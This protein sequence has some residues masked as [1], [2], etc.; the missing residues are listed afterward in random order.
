M[1][2]DSV[3]TASKKAIR[4]RA[5]A[6]AA[7]FASSTSE[8]AD[9]QTFWNEFFA[10]F[11]IDRKQVAAFE[12]LAKRA[13][14]GNHGWIDLLY[15]GKMGVEHKSAGENLDAAMG[16]LLDY[17]PSLPQVEH[18]WLLVACDFAHFK[19]HNLNDGTSG[20][21]TLS[22]LPDN[23]DLFWW[24]A[25]YD[26]P[27]RVYG[28]LEDANLKATELMAA[29]YDH[30]AANGY[31]DHALREWLT[32]LLFCLF[33]DDTGVW[34]RAA[35]HAYLSVHTRQD[36]SD[37]G[38]QLAY[39]FQ[40]MNTPPSERPKNLDEDVDQFIYV[41]GDLFAEA[42]PI[43]TCDQETRDAV[44]AA[45]TFDWSAISPAIFG[46]MFQN[47]MTPAE[48]RQLG[49]HYTTEENILRTIRPL[50]LDDLGAELEAATT[51]PK[52]EAYLS[53]LAGLTFFD[54]AAG[55]G[56]FLVISYREIRALETEA[57]RRLQAKQGR[58]GQLSIDVTLACKVRVDQFYGIEIEEFPAK[59]ARTALY[60]MDHQCNRA[61]SAEFGQHYAR[62]PIPAAP[63]IENANALRVDWNSV[64]PGHRADYVV[65]N[66]P[67]IGMALMTPDQDDDASAVFGQLNA[68]GLRTG[69]LDYVACW[70]ALAYLY[71][72][73]NRTKFAFVSTN[74]IT[75]GEQ[76]RSLGPLMTRYG[77]HIDFA[78]RTFR[79]TSEARGK[80]AVHVVIVGFSQAGGNTKKRLFDYPDISGEPIETVATHINWYLADAPD[81]HIG[82]H[83]APFAPGLPK[84]TEGNR[85]ED[86]GG[87]IVEDEEVAD[88]RAQDP[89]AAK[90]LRPLVGA[91]D[92]LNGG[93]RWCLWL[94]DATPQ[95]LRTSPV[96]K[97]RLAQTAKVRM[98][99]VDK[100]RSEARK[101]KLRQLAAKPAL[102]TAIRQPQG[103]YLCVPRHSSENRRIV[104]M[105]LLDPTSIAHD[106]TLTA[107]GMP[108]WAFAVM[109]SSMYTA[110]LRN[111]GGRLKSDIR[112]APDLCYNAFPFLQ[113]DSKQ[114][115]E[116]AALASL[117]LEVRKGHPGSSLAD[118]YDPV[119]TPPDLTD[120]HD[121]LDKAVDR[122]YAGKRKLRTDA[123]RLAVLFEHYITL[124]E[125]GKIFPAAPSSPRRRRKN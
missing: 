73:G 17:L 25:H 12:L 78:H 112:V 75:Q 9:R 4:S 21:F 74:S 103:R 28:N 41:N 109:Q 39:L 106:S 120:A 80:A 88:I 24:I 97:G 100:T 49:A 45:C 124:T 3:A 65:S 81:V 63:N 91:K 52:L 53:K 85:P 98:A 107:D 57:L 47:V 34:D 111:I 71:G 37:L 42:L 64:L 76:A 27:N 66:P 90:Y 123:D 115:K 94:V 114:E 38:S 54:P 6:F 5:T 62:F 14:T 13:S 69:R 93:R 22:E 50:F 7:R 83:T 89:V 92:M 33:A 23:L 119:S 56:N 79:W 121:K 2:D 58:A 35:F 20:E 82:K 117:I 16:Q 104:P 113:P 55:C 125:A 29:I 96:L 116:L 1:S 122:I 99:A 68:E 40:I 51:K 19:W 15:P 59:I 46:S 95:E 72:R 118:L 60:L 36:G 86:G 32:R 30:L 8:Q 31:P 26:D 18:P 11:G 110:W 10:I 102:F 44:L 108:L 67:F 70:Y 101:Q 77:Y 43:P 87:L 48:R 105:T 84:L 61:I